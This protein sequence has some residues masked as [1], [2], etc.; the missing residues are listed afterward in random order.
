M[1]SP[2]S[3]STLKILLHELFP[4]WSWKSKRRQVLFVL[5]NTEWLRTVEGIGDRFDSIR[6]S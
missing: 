1:L 6:R 2:Y 5:P 4:R 3:V